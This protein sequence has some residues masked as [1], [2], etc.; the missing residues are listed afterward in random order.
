MAN[1]I[2]IQDRPLDSTNASAA[3]GAIEAFDTDVCLGGRLNKVVETVRD[4]SSS[5]PINQN[6]I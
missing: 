2:V 5:S 1:A 6:I 4:A 3:E